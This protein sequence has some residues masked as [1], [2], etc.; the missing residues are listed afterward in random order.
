MRKHHGNYF[1]PFS[2]GRGGF[3]KDFFTVPT[4]M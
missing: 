1:M 4:F 3:E 2:G